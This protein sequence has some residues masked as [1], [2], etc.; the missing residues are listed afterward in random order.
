M[1]RYA[2]SPGA[3][4]DA[5]DVRADELVSRA[6]ELARGGVDFILLREKTLRDEEMVGLTRRVVAECAGTAARVVVRGSVAQGVHLGGGSGVG[7][8]G[9][10]REGIPGTWVSV[11]C[12][13]VEEVER[14]RLEGADAVLFAP[15]FGKVLDGV[16][17]VG[18]VGLERLREACVAAGPMAVFALGGVD[19]GN[20]AACVEAGAAGVAGIRMFFADG[21]RVDLRGARS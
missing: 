12:H 8:V 4:R 5:V 9:G 19:A 10:V 18:G 11:S 20:A 16:E 17:V 3:V 6:G 2:I 7:L 13:G 14:A 21:V 1:L 15:V